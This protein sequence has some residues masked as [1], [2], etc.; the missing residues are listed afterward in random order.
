MGNLL[1]VQRTHFTRN[2][3]IKQDWI[4]IDA[5]GQNLGRL[6]SRIAYRLR[7]KHRTDYASHQNIGDQIVVINAR[8]V[9]VSGN[10]GEQKIYYRHTGYTGNLRKIRFGEMLAKHPENILKLAVKR[11]L[12]AGPLG[13]NLLSNLHIYAEDQHLHNAQKPQKWEPVFK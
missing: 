9:H 6:A 4:L 7:G 13:R 12:P 11:M 3:D 1:K 10:K 8:Q 5:A 2:E